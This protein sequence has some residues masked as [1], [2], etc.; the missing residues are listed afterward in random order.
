MSYYLKDNQKKQ[1]TIGCNIKI[2][3]I[4]DVKN[5]LDWNLKIKVDINVLLNL[6]KCI[7]Q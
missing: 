5:V 2:I 4:L 3:K 6:E 1:T 7:E